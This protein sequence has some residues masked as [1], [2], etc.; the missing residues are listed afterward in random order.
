MPSHPGDR[1]IRLDLANALAWSGRPDDA[2]PLYDQLLRDEPA[3]PDLLRARANALRWDGRLEEAA[4]A[5]RRT[6]RA[7][8]LPAL[9][10]L[11]RGA[12]GFF[13][14]FMCRSSCDT[15]S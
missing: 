15:S 8:P 12:G 10:P 5:Y 2:I 14:G 7:A 11:V 1:A 4:D 13:F 3:R 6:L 9:P